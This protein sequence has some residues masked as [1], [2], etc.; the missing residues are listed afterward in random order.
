MPYALRGNQLPHAR[1]DA[2]QVRAIRENRN[3]WTAR[4]WGKALG[5]HHRTIE[6]VRH[7]ETWVHVR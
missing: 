5:V 6:K 3:G 1:L 2:N 7:Y 4:Q